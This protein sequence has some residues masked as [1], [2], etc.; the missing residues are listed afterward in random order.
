MI[1]LPAAAIAHFLGGLSE[2]GSWLD[3]KL[4]VDEMKLLPVVIRN[5]LD[6]EAVYYP[7]RN[8]DFRVWQAEHNRGGD[9]LIY[10]D[11]ATLRLP[12]PIHLDLGK[13][14]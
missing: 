9:F 2:E 3:M 10:S 8:R 4:E 12:Q 13:A 6:P 7:V 1:L 11:L 5:Q 14:C